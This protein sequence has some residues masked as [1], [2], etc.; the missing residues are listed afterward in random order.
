MEGALIGNWIV[1]KPLGEG[2]MGQVYLARHRLL[3]TLAALKVLSVS[4]TQDRSFHERFLQEAQ[5]QSQLQ[6][7]NIA[8]VMDF[9]EHEDRYYL[10]IEHLSGGTLAGV[11][12]STG[13]PLDTSLALT[14]TKEVLSALDYAHQRG[15]IHRDIKTS[16]IMFDEAGAAK[17]TDFGIALVMGGKRLTN[18]G[19]AMGTPEYMSPE[20]IVRPKDVDHRTDVYSVGIVLYEMLS[21]RV[22]FQ[23]DTDFAVRTA[24]VNDPPPPLGDFNPAIGEALEQTVMR[25]LA[26]DPDQ[27]YLGCGEFI[28]ALEE[29]SLDRMPAGR[30]PQIVPTAGGVEQAEPIYHG[31]PRFPGPGP[32]RQTLVEADSSIDRDQ[33]VGQISGPILSPISVPISAPPSA[34][35]TVTPAGTV[36]KE[37]RLGFTLS[38]LAIAGVIVAAVA[39]LAIS[40]RPLTAADYVSRGDELAN[41]RNWAAA[42]PEYRH[43]EQ[44]DPSDTLTHF[45]LWTALARQN[46]YEEGQPERKLVDEPQKWSQIEAYYR[47][48]LLTD[49][50]RAENHCLLGVALDFQQKNSE[51]L[52]E[53]REAVRLDPGYAI[54]HSDLGGFLLTQGK[55]DEGLAEY[56]EAMRL[57]PSLWAPHYFLGLDLLDHKK[58]KEAE[59]D[60]RE[61]TRL[62]PGNSGGHYGLG[63][64][65][66]GQVRLGEAEPEFREAIRLEPE[67][68]HSH[69]FLGLT[70]F[71]EHK[72]HE[73]EAEFR[74]AIRLN[75]NDST[76]HNGL[77][78]ALENQGDLVGAEAEYKEAVRLDPEYTDAQTNLKKL[79]SKRSGSR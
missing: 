15:V 56:R 49:P 33:L 19:T 74:E 77:G 2:G 27:R 75:P 40:R 59:P 44:L 16:N 45:K 47:K 21:G 1:E 69:Y 41:A 48:L 3:N 30:S 46:K 12:E 11:I 24:Q 31:D 62:F 51:A 61:A 50:G 26:K 17:V 7:S 32:R 9:I 14:W 64:S 43:A 28:S 22:P 35:V 79:G 37:R 73:A 34:P 38:V 29:L 4:L 20:Q 18:T 76:A 55:Y 36:K 60:L 65:L 52:T 8:R 63:T 72:Y 78:Q 68:Q 57:D 39:W 54:Y 6:H 25:A 66:L 42:E 23:G 71:Y 67:H 13:G 70:L 10:V 5:T 58:Y 53:Y